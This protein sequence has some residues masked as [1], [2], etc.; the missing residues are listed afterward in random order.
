M[1]LNNLVVALRNAWR[2]KIYT[3]INLL[4]LSMGIASS[5]IILLFVLDEVSF[6][7]HNEHFSDIYRICIRGKIQGNELEA[8]LSNAPMGATLKSDFPEVEEF[9]RL[10]TFDGDPIVRY[11]DKV[12]IEEN[13]YYADSTF[14]NV[15]TAPVVFGDPGGLLNRP[16]TVVLTEEASRKYFG[17]E[18]PVGKMLYVGQ[19][20]REFEVSGVVKGFPENSHFRFNMLGS[21]SSI[22]IADRT[23][24]L[25]NNNYTYIRL[26]RGVDP[27][28]VE[29]KFPDLVAAHMGPQLEEILGLTMEEFFASGNTYG[30]FLQPLGKIHLES[31][32]QFEINPGG[33][34]ASVIIFSVIAVFLIIIASINFMNLAT[35]SAA[36][37]ATEVGI[38]KA[39]GA[40]KKR[41][42]R[43]FLTESFLVTS[44]ALVLA[45][46]MVELAL[47]GFNDLAGKKLQL[48]ALE[49]W[50]LFVGML[51][52][53]IFVG[54]V[55][56]SYPAFFLSSFKPAAVLK[57]GAMRGIRGNGL[58]RVLVTFQFVVTIVLF[59]CTMV[60][61]RQM[62]F[63]QSK[64]LGF[65]KENLVVIDRVHVLENRLDAFRQELLRNPLVLKATASSEVPGGLIGDN[66]FLPEGEAAD[67][68]HSINNIW[69]DWYFMET[70]QLE[71]IQGRWFRE[72][73]PT[74]SMALIMNQAAVRALGFENPLDKRLYATFGEDT[75][76]PLPVIGVVRDFY[77]QSLHQEVRPLIIQFARDSRYKLTVRISGNQT[78]ETLHFIEKTWDAFIEQQPI[79][80]TFLKEDLAVLYHNDEKTATVFSI[81]SVLAIFIAAL[82]LLGLASFSAAQRTKEV[83]IRKAM[84]AS[85]SGVL[86]TLSKEF[87]WLI[88]IATLAAWPIA[89]FIMKDWL[90]NYPIR[91]GLELQVFIISSLLAF[92]V[93][94][95]TVLVRVFQ[96][97]SMN[98]V[99]SLRY[100]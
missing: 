100:E 82:G 22:Y 19:R 65:N 89:Y 36:K 39:A 79:H 92:I 33:S 16:N 80:M 35:A 14:F 13:F 71:M 76:I 55:S 41:L 61:N 58:R 45:I 32:L 86:I 7:R 93:A 81:F 77:F 5:M 44:M 50:K 40:D 28:S 30:Y 73:N 24:W 70:Y 3:F 48:D 12:F 85:V 9:T 91:I 84:G 25:G 26:R 97:A 46:V 90:Q 98:P 21:M 1:I 34:K 95:V 87:I 20:E 72:D 15:F 56:G 75:G 18:D 6:D 17:N 10:F 23:E 99:M 47:P 64:D 51:F 57:S 68:T 67:E 8:A 11:N 38:R 42:I 54:F 4:G 59:I 96:A 52:I 27:D 29:A 43:Q 31:D 69:A 83:G 49:G 37:R 62:K 63:L 66:A 53:G 94:S 2:N 60:V 78:A 88:L 74:D